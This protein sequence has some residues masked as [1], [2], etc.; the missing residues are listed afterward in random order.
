MTVEHTKDRRALAAILHAVPSKMKEF[1]NITF[2]DGESVD[3]S[4]KHINGLVASLR[5]LAINNIAAQLNS[6]EPL[7]GTNFPSW[8]D[9]ILIML[10][11]LD[12][13]LASREDDPIAPFVDNENYVE[14]KKVYDALGEGQ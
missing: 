11:V 3:E 2:H 14:F 1:E 4:T 5:E 7:N 6:N 12:Y 8:K 13:D 9:K 10:G